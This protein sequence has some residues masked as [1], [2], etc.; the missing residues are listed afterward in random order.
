V[1]R[2]QARADVADL[3]LLALCRG[4]T[5][6]IG[7]GPGRL[8]RELLERGLPAMGIDIVPEAVRQT[9]ARGGLALERDVFAAIPAEGR[10]ATALLADGNLGIGGD[11]VRLLRRISRIVSSSG[12]IV[13]ELDPPGGGVRRHRVVLQVGAIRTRPFSWA[14]VPVDE[15]ARVADAASLRVVETASAGRRRFAAL[16]RTDGD[17]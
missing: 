5:V 12:R 2:W 8:T 11:P 3:A 17:A 14:V 1:G 15:I 16:T 7:C 13:V 6:D 4:A 9:R 10:W